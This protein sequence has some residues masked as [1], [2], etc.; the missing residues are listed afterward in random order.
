MC[1]IHLYYVPAN[2]GSRLHSAIVVHLQIIKATVN[3][4]LQVEGVK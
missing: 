4:E 3:V 1:V 2:L